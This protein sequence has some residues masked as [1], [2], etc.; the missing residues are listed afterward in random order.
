MSR[1]IVA[2]VLPLFSNFRLVTRLKVAWLVLFSREV[3][4][5]RDLLSKNNAEKNLQTEGRSSE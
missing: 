5:L 4:G 1:F 2:I 3:G